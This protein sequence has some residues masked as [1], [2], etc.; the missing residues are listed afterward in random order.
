[1]FKNLRLV[2]LLGN[3]LFVLWLLWNGIN[4]G[5]K[6][7]PMQLVSYIALICLLFFNSILLYLK[8]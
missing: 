2:A 1:M 7:T 8:K 3:G 5:F 4:E 6:A